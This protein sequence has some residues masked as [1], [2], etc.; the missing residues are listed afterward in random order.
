MAVLLFVWWTIAL[1]FCLVLWM[2][3][4]KSNAFVRFCCR[5]NKALCSDIHTWTV[6]SQLRRGVAASTSLSQMTGLLQILYHT[7]CTICKLR[8]FLCLNSIFRCL[9][10]VADCGRILP[11]YSAMLTLLQSTILTVSMMLLCNTRAPCGKG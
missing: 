8:V 1:F 2:P 9:S 4:F 7:V 5:W 6:D 10:S 11:V 3:G